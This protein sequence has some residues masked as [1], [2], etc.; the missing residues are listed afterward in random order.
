MSIPNEALQKLVQE[1]E[2]QAR[3]AQTELVIVKNALAGKQR[4]VRLLELTN[5][6]M[7]SL[8]RDT[9]LYNGVGKMFV[10][11]SRSDMEEGSKKQMDEIKGDISNLNKKLNYLET[12]HQN[13]R[14]HIDQIFSSGGRS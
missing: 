14:R 7:R 5:T 6:E 11:T 9:K 3:A 13:S 10:Q 4:E 8:P 12:T 2:S 1:I